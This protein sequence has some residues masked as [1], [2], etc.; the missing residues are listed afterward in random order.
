M[1]MTPLKSHLAVSVSVTEPIQYRTYLIMNLYNLERI[2]LSLNL[3]DSEPFR[4]FLIFRIPNLLDSEPIGFCIYQFRAYWIPNL[5]DSEPIGFR[6]Y[7][8]PNL[9]HTNS[10]TIMNLSE[11]ETMRYQAVSPIPS[12]PF[13]S[14]SPS[15]PP[16]LHHPSPCND[17]QSPL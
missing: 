10:D 7:R 11:T 15:A 9:S 6:T 17:C 12:T 4:F 3:S 16:Q 13:P 1:S 2:Y 14:L 5:S 8:I